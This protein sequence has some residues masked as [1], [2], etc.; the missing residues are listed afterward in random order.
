MTNQIIP[1]IDVA[2]QGA[3]VVDQLTSALGLPRTLLPENE[4]ITHAL[5]ELPRHLNR[6]PPQ[7]RD[8]F[9][10]KAVVAASVG[11][12]DGAIVY[13]WD[14]VIQQIRHKIE[15]FGTPMIK[16]VLNREKDATLSELT[17]SQ[18]L[19]LAYQLNLMDRQGFLFL[20]Q[21][22]EI[23]NQASVAHPSDI[24]LDDV[25]FIV[26]VSRCAK[27][28]LS[29]AE[30]QSGVSLQTVISLI[31]NE[32]A[33]DDA[34]A[35]LGSQIAHTFELQRNFFVGLLYSKYVNPSNPTHQRENALKLVMKFSSEISD[36]SK[37]DILSRH[38]E[39]LAKGDTEKKSAANSRQFFSKIGMLNDLGN[40]EQVAI[41]TKAIENLQNAHLGFNNF[42]TEPPFAERL[43]EISIQISPLPAVVIGSFVQVVFQAYL[44]NPW[45]V[46][47]QAMPFYSKMLKNLTP[48]GIEVLLHELDRL[49]KG[50]LNDWKIAPVY[51]SSATP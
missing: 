33:G 35:E 17:D 43:E 15:A 6:I 37:S 51:N 39:I 34:I 1:I 24:G 36:K 3:A 50:N 4:E 18:T 20:S 40:A 28:G 47:S 25:E 42:Y 48:Q 30:D 27:Y 31:E 49:E 11:L 32:S 21:C 23:R 22:R 2:K 9:I 19:E 14:A 46:S 5:Q 44:G 29:D 10:A 41:C 8:Q 45:G 16:T 7:L 13:I 12:F 26:F 38:T